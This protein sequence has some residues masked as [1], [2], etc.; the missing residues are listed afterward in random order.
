MTLTKQSKQREKASPEMDHSPPWGGRPASKPVSSAASSEQ[1]QARTDGV[2]A[3]VGGF[4][5]FFNH[6]TQ[7][8]Q[9]EQMT[10]SLE[11]AAK[12]EA[13]NDKP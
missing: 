10:Y 11:Q 2:C 4:C 5:F 9:T 13:A 8:E 1:S 6:R 7:S 12:S 3:R